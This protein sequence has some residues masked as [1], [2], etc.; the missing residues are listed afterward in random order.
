MEKKKKDV[1]HWASRN[2]GEDTQHGRAI[3]TEKQQ[4]GMW[5]IE[6]EH[7]EAVTPSIFEEKRPTGST[8]WFMLVVVSPMCVLK[9]SGKLDYRFESI[10]GIRAIR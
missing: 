4:D 2:S 10:F 1:I 5:D 8:S 6:V 3:H 9:H 7:G